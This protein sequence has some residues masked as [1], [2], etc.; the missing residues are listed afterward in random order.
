[1]PALGE[2]GLGE[3]GL[4]EGGAA[5]LEPVLGLLGRTWPTLYGRTA[6]QP[7]DQHR[8]DPVV[9][10]LCRL[11]Q[12]GLLA[13]ATEVARRTSYATAGGPPGG[14]VVRAASW[15]IDPRFGPVER[16]CLAYTEAFVSIR[17]ASATTTPPTVRELLGERGLVALTTAL[18]LFDGQCRL[19]L[20]LEVS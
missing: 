9:L 15:P 14:V 11:R 16:T 7:L 8:L 6:R 19:H 2:R 3:G 1:M 20:A 17:T 13:C 5:S 12:A 10:E 4:G 18:G